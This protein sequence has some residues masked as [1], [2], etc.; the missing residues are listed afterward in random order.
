MK[1]LYNNLKEVLE[2]QGFNIAPYGEH[3]NMMD[4]RSIRLEMGTIT[5]LSPCF[6]MYTVT[7]TVFFINGFNW[8]EY[9]AKLSDALMSFIPMTDRPDEESQQLPDNSTKMTLLDVPEFGEIETTF[10][11]DNGEEEHSVSVTIHYSN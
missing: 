1:K 8:A 11:E 7:F 4:E 6:D 2:Q 5:P 10:D 9:A 3:T